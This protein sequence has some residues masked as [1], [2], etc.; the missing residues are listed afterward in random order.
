MVL[1]GPIFRFW[2]KGARVLC[3]DGTFAPFI[4]AYSSYMKLVTRMMMYDHLSQGTLMIKKAD[5]LV[6]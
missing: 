1:I 4:I 2:M 3:G 6:E 5:L